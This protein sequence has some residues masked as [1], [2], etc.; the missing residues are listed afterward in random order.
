M[1]MK[2][3]EEEAL[4]DSL[5]PKLSEE[6]QHIIAILLDAHHKTYDPTYADFR[7]FRVRLPACGL[8]QASGESGIAQARGAG[9]EG[10]DPGKVRRLCCPRR[11]L[12]LS[13]QTFALR[14]RRGALK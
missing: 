8:N 4:K 6:Q 13:L 9:L 1:I 5:R 12:P 11:A 14:G 3:K 7:D 10:W 2:R